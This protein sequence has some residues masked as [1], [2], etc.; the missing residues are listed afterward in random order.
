MAFLHPEDM[1]ER[2]VGPVSYRIASAE[3][4]MMLHLTIPPDTYLPAHAHENFQLGYVLSGSATL[5]IGGETA[6]VGPGMAYTIP[7]NV[8]HDLQTGDEPLELLD[9]YYPPKGDRL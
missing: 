1:P 4:V 5:S 8:P 3:P 6:R 9:I 2:R 7:A